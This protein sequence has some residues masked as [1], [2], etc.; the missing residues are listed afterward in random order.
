MEE[1]S[2]ASDFSISQINFVGNKNA[3]T[4]RG[5]HFQ[6][7]PS[8]EAKVIFCLAGEVFDL[9]LDVRAGSDTLGHAASFY[10]TPG[11]GLLL[12]CGIAHGYQTLVD[13]SEMLYLHT[14]PYDP[15]YDHGI[16]YENQYC[17]VSW[18]L[19]IAQM[20]EKDCNLPTDSIYEMS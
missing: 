8:T 11:S 16:H 2:K 17:Q 13:N 1:F 6:Q 15:R 18:P 19:P 12:P 9:C 10:L 5:L 7:A 14:A 3:G 20:S 4:V